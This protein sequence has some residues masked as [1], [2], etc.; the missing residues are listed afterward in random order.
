[1]AQRRFPCSG[2][3][4]VKV[5]RVCLLKLKFRSAGFR[6]LSLSADISVR[7][8][9]LRWTLR[10]LYGLG[11]GQGRAWD[12]HLLAENRVHPLRL[13]NPNS[14][15]WSWL[16]RLAASQNSEALILT[17]KLSPTA[18]KRDACFLGEGPPL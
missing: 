8:Q 6:L 1:M 17:L 11:G 16:T 3:Q 18:S 13:K 10:V 15:N 2:H 5:L 12:F 9:G 7:A 4:M 14:N